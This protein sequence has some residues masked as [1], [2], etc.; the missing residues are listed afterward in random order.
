MMIIEDMEYE[1]NKTDE[2]CKN[3]RNEL[4]FMNN[5]TKNKY[6]MITNISEMRV[7]RTF[8]GWKKNSMLRIMS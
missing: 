3:A 4:E 5:V 8:L 2:I 7:R 1:M 6:R